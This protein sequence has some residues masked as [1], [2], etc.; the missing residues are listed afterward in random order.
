MRRILRKFRN[1]YYTVFLI[2]RLLLP[3]VLTIFILIML[4]AVFIL[5]AIIHPGRTKEVINP[6][7]FYMAAKEFTWDGA[8]GDVLTGWYIRSSNQAPLIILC[9]GYESNR[10]VVLSLASR[11]KDNGYNVFIYN[12][13]GHGESNFIISSLGLYEA[14]DLRRAIEKLATQPEVDFNRIGIYG[15]SMG[16]YV[17]LEASKNNP[18]V[19]ALALDSPYRSIKSFIHLEVQEVVGMQFSL[20]SNIVTLLYD[21]YFRVS[22]STV[23]QEFSPNDF[24]DKSILFIFGSDKRSAGLA[25][26]TRQLFS[27]LNCRKDLLTLPNSIDSI[28]FGDEKHRY[29]QNVVDFFKRDLP[30]D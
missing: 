21:I 9:H 7:H 15:S 25:K 16:A 6:S 10:T 24:S 29:D 17:A 19:K 12:L 5:S 18:R 11:L 26:E 2:L 3:V 13:R 20:L 23:S 1:R 28:L 30:L 4:A 8:N 27:R 14:E 22:P